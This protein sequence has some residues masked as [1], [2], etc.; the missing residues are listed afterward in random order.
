MAQYQSFPDADGDSRTLDKLKALKLPDLAGLTFLDVGC[1]EGFF[2]GFAK[3]QGAQRVVG[4]DQSRGFIDR[5]RRRFP[6]CE[7]YQQNWDSLPE[8]QFDVILLASALHYADDQAALVGRL[9]ERLSPD[10]VLVLELGIV[11]KKE[12]EWVKVE[13][14]IDQRYFPT[15]AKLTEV[16]APFAWKWMGPSVSQS[17]DPI[18]RHVLHI[19]RRRPIAYLL[20]QP[21]GYGKSSISTRLFV[22]AG[23]PV[24]SGDQQ[25]SLVAQGKKSVS[26]ALHEVINRD[27]S[28]FHL[29][30]TLQRVFDQGAGSELIGLCI[31]EAGSAR[32]LALDMYVPVEHHATV[33]KAFSEKAYLPV[34]M[35]WDRVG[36]S[37]TSEQVQEER[38]RAYYL[39]MP[40]PSMATRTGKSGF[41]GIVGFVDDVRLKG[42][43]LL[44]RGWAVDENGQLP[45]Q[46]NVRI[47][48]QV[49]PAESLQALERPDVQH[50]LK[51]AN[52]HVGF[53]ILLKIPALT[54]YQDIAGDFEVVTTTGKKLRLTRKVAETLAMK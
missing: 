18:A 19:S 37:P 53:R 1:N 52:A 23:V 54:G 20:L 32:D 43:N 31:E 24:I 51:S 15:M 11:S 9:V 14:G 3:F 36:P 46:L 25:I 35:L 13:R 49:F 8:G 48:G 47:R 50:H 30:Q 17:G 33:E 41:S 2:C 10:G 22:P 12:S 16:L 21:P 4:I 40:A 26:Q 38:A 5:A 7:F 39:A 44:V 29:D 27:Y 6:D 28:P 45:A 34:L 42:G